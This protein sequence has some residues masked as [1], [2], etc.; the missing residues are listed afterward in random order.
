MTNNFFS[1]GFHVLGYLLLYFSACVN[2]IIYVIMNKQ[3]RQA[4][5]TVLLCRKP[6]LRS[7]TPANHSSCAGNVSLHLQSV[8][9]VRTKVQSSHESIPDK[10]DNRDNVVGSVQQEQAHFGSF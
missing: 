8:P 5:K 2:P 9:E 3:Y 4:Y 6:R 7:S 10:Q 1:L